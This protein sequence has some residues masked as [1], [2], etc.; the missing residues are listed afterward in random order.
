MVNISKGLLGL[1]EG[2][3]AQR[4]IGGLM[5]QEAS[6][7]EGRAYTEAMRKEAEERADLRQIASEE[8]ADE[9]YAKRLEDEERIWFERAKETREG[10]M[11]LYVRQFGMESARQIK[12]FNMESMRQIRLALDKA[13]SAEEIAKIEA[14]GDQMSQLSS[15]L[16]ALHEHRPDDAKWNSDTKKWDDDGQWWDKVQAKEREYNKAAANLG[17]KPLSEKKDSYRYGPNA[18]LIYDTVRNSTPEGGENWDDLMTAISGDKES[19]GYKAALE[20]INKAVDDYIKSPNSPYSQMTGSEQFKLRKTTVDLFTREG[21]GFV[22][23]DPGDSEAPPPQPTTVSGVDVETDTIR[24][25]GHQFEDNIDLER[26]GQAGSVSEISER[27]KR[28]PGGFR[29][30]TLRREL[31]AAQRTDPQYLLPRL[32]K[33]RDALQAQ[34][35]TPARGRGA[36]GRRMS[37]ARL[38]KLNSMIMQI[39]TFLNQEFM[40]TGPTGGGMLNR[41]GMI[42]MFESGPGLDMSAEAVESRIA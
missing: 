26:I 37:E 5:F 27:I 6:R 38:A 7:Q 42:Q 16:E 32:I 31:I 12:M 29:N 21:H 33:E 1:A 19:S 3:D 17:L 25:P 39:E 13:T 18:A 24:P 30:N 15:Q 8:R 14:Q 10:E 4:D 9:R 22:A 23:S 11:N 20:T 28:T 35:S 2:V 40:D 34:L 41:P 36:G